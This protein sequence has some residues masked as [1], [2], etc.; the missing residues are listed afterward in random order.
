MLQNVIDFHL[1]NCCHLL[2]F[3]YRITYKKGLKGFLYCYQ[4]YLN[5]YFYHLIN[6]YGHFCYYVFLL[7]NGQK[8]GVTIFYNLCIFLISFYSFPISHQLL[9]KNVLNVIFTSW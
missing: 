2:V 4:I 6:T 7:K 1:E 5:L 9:N 8:R 3:D